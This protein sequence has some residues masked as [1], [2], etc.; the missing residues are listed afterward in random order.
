MID[1]IEWKGGPTPVDRDVKIE[2]RYR[3]FNTKVGYFG[4]SDNS[5]RWN[6]TG[7]SDDII[8]YRVISVDEH[9]IPINIH[10][11]E[12]RIIPTEIAEHPLF[13][14][15]IDAI[16]QATKGKGQ[17]HGGDVTP[18][19]EQQ[20]VA[21]AKSHGVGFLTGQASKKLNEAAVKTLAGAY[22][23]EPFEREV[24]GAIVYA[25]MAVLNARGLT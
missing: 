13:D 6:H 7:A 22:E 10:K 12:I 23:T 9:S 19:L 2:V 17:R 15:L 18:F 16:K 14:V 3:S 24:L 4:G 21:L 5:Y 1:W 25:G 20:W 8:A 11:P